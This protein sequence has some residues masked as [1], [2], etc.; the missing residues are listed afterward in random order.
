MKRIQIDK[1]QYNEI[2]GLQLMQ[3]INFL[4]RELAAEHEWES[5]LNEAKKRLANK[6]YKG[7]R[8][9]SKYEKIYEQC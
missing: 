3:K 5:I 6:F 2:I 9:V 7:F 1:I 8:D 4:A